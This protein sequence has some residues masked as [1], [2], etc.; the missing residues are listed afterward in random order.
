MKRQY[1]LFLRLEYELKKPRKSK[2]L[3][4]MTLI[5]FDKPAQRAGVPAFN[6]FFN[7]FFANP[8]HPVFKPFGSGS[9]SPA[10]NIS[11]TDESF[12]LEFTVA[13]FSKEEITLAV[14]KNTLSVSGEKKA[15]KT[16][17]EKRYTRK[18][19]V[20][21]NFKRSFNLPENVNQD[22]IGARFEN[23][24]LLVEL[25]KKEFEPKTVRKIE[26]Q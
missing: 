23:G 22:K 19:F 9:T 5:K 1:G 10:V 26:L 12:N 25:P 7:D 20:F 13:G 2:K 15:E 16:Q 6:N 3:K 14:E 24:I 21:Q 11:E 8:D 18:E 4:T 17:S